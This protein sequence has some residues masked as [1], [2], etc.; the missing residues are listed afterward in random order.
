MSVSI[1]VRA[2]LVC[3]AAGAL[4]AQVQVSLGAGSGCNALQGGQTCTLSARVSGA[5]NFNVAWTFSPPVAGATLG[6]PTV[7]R[8][9]RR[10][11]SYVQ[12]RRQGREAARRRDCLSDA[13]SP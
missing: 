4:P 11:R 1:L 7:W 2:S 6:V 5:A 9:G 13:D 12:T 8:S 10:S 3:L